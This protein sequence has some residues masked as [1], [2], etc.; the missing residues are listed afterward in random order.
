MSDIIAVLPDSVANQ[1]A[2][3][4]VI[5]RPASVIKE[6]ME[7]ALDAEATDITVIIKDAGKNLIQII[8]NG[9]GMSETD[10]R[11]SFERHATSKIRNADDLFALKS[12]GF[13]GEALA[14]VAAIASVEL[15]T[16]QP[17]TELGT[18]IVITGSKVESQQPI[19]CPTGANFIIRNL[20]YNVPA[21]RKFLKS[22]SAEIKH[23]ITEF[24]HVALTRPDVAFTLISDE[25]VLYKLQSGNLKQRI[26]ALFPNAGKNLI[27]VGTITG[28]VEIEGFIGNPET[29]RKSS[30]D[31]YFFVNDR[32]MRHPYFHKA[33]MDAYE[34]ILPTNVVPAYFIYFKINPEQID[35]NIHPTKTEIK[36]A[37]AP[38][39]YSILR[40]TVKEAIGK[41]NIAPPLDFD[42]EDAPDIPLIDRNKPIIPPSVTYNPNYNPFEIKKENT[43]SKSNALNANADFYKES[44][45]AIRN[46]NAMFSGEIYPSKFNE[47]PAEN[48]SI[49]LE[50]QQNEN[51]TADNKSFYIYKSKYLVKSVKSG[52]MLIHISRARERIMY[53]H[54]LAIKDNKAV[55]SQQLLFPVTYQFPVSDMPLFVEIAE[56]LADLGFDVREFGRNTV[57]INGYPPDFTGTDPLSLFLEVFENYKLTRSDITIEYRDKLIRSMVAAGSKSFNKALHEQEIELLADNLFACRE[58]NY[59]ADGKKII[60]IW[61]H[62]EIEKNFNR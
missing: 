35:V 5:Q 29:A 47:L 61:Q 58:P 39:V 30:G 54:F 6:L 53:E 27:P 37:E 14:S 41:F 57:I 43:G 22:D 33:V 38:S 62:D 44:P 11:M 19:N 55:S 1:I 2:A 7:N 20:F 8:D 25:T 13:R 42:M 18:H 23:I 24:Q 21:R 3:G 48:E 32:Y 60:F 45:E 52:L 56:D 40:V 31:Q 36:F 9:K 50:I 59:T 46:Y 28:I 34:G 26:G 49:Q 16:K 12:M 10:A 4:E 51:I 15:K 17:N